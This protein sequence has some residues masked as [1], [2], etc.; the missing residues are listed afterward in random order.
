MV[1]TQ[2]WQRGWL[3]VDKAIQMKQDLLLI[4]ESIYNLDESILRENFH[5]QFDDSP[6]KPKLE[7]AFEIELNILSEAER[8]KLSLYLVIS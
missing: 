6:I 8:A 2:S 1:P 3:P 7:R 4:K 5:N